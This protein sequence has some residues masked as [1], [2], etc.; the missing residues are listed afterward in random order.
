ML[1]SFEGIAPSTRR[2]DVSNG[3]S[4]TLTQKYTFGL[5]CILKEIWGDMKVEEEKGVKDTSRSE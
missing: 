1:L 2:W 3:M 4:E 5:H